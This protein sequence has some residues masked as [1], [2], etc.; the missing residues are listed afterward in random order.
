[1][2][3]VCADEQIKNAGF[4]AKIKRHTDTVLGKRTDPFRYACLLLSLPSFDTAGVSA[5]PHNAL[6]DAQ[7]LAAYVEGNLSGER[8]GMEEAD[9]AL[10]RNTCGESTVA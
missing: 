7:A 5:V 10:L 9:L 6:A 8:G 4:V 3:A 1:M 2:N